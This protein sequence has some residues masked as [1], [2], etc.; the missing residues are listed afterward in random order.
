MCMN[1][2]QKTVG[3]RES[4]ETLGARLPRRLLLGGSLYKLTQVAQARRLGH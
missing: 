3:G 1:F 4:L 2:S